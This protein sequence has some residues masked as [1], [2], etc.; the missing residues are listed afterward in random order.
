MLGLTHVA[1][2]CNRTDNPS[3]AGGRHGLRLPRLFGIAVLVVAAVLA[4]LVYGLHIMPGDVST[5]APGLQNATIGQS[6]SVD[7][8]ELQKATV[9]RVVDGDT[10]VVDRGEGEEKVRLIGVNTPESVAEDESRNTEE[11]DEAKRYTESLVSEGDIV[12]LQKEVSDTDRYG[13]LLRHVWLEAPTD[14]RDEEQVR[15]KMLDG[16]LVYQG[17]AESKR[18]GKDTQYADMFD[19]FM[20]DALENGRGLASFWQ[21]PNHPE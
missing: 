2:R 19:G 17:Y 1:D 7:G 8:D 4:V 15:E 10:L 16:I 5:G 12:Y 6:V 21:D 18:Y 3:D 20:E 14:T 13:R 11:G 9:V